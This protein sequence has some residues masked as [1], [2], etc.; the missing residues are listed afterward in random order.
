MEKTII[1]ADD[2]EILRELTEN[3]LKATLDGNYLFEHIS[4]GKALDKR[5]NY[6]CSGIVLAIVDRHMPPD[7]DGEEIIKRYAREIPII[8]YYD[9]SGVDDAPGKRALENG[10]RAY[11]LKPNYEGVAKI[12]RQIL[13]PLEA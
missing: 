10:A 9:P 6:G 11:F 5:L 2:H 8:F 1:I 7:P 12:A 13:E 4:N 3:Y